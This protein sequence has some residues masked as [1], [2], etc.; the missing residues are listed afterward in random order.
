MSVDGSVVVMTLNPIQQIALGAMLC[1]S[2][3][4]K[5]FQGSQPKF[6]SIFRLELS[7]VKDASLKLPVEPQTK[8]VF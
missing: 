1:H 8:A 5:G 4:S 6:K 7:L 3:N 2:R